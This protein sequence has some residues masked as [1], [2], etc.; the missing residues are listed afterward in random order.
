ML[1]F[2]GLKF[3]DISIIN[4]ISNS[5]PKKPRESGFSPVNS[6]SVVF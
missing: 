3:D 6:Y 5:F 1:I 4:N 2:E